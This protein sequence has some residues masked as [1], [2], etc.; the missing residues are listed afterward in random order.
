M[1]LPLSGTD[2]FRVEARRHWSQPRLA[3][4][5]AEGLPEQHGPSWGSKHT[6]LLQRVTHTPCTLCILP[7]QA[8]PL[9]TES[10][11]RWRGPFTV[12]A[13]AFTVFLWSIIFVIVDIP[14]PC[15][16]CPAPGAR[17]KCLV[18]GQFEICGWGKE[19]E[20]NWKATPKGRRRGAQGD[21]GRRV[22]DPSIPWHPY[23]PFGIWSQD[24]DTPGD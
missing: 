19:E 20:R 17:R 3:R 15:L 8:Q 6:P 24:R 13:A 10:L 9:R 22:L 1:P 23:E 21:Y 16:S 14:P 11:G 2:K 4:C 18:L 5:D 12:S 7:Y